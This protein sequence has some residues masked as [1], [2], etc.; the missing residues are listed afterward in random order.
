MDKEFNFL[1]NF[2]R[3]VT[4][5]D[6]VKR[7]QL[8]WVSLNVTM[9]KSGESVRIKQFLR[10]LVCL[11]RQSRLLYVLEMLEKNLGSVSGG[12]FPNLKCNQ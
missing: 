6:G 5:D 8:S 9:G 11:S 10:S 4:S 3:D 1:C 12:W 7:D 2:S